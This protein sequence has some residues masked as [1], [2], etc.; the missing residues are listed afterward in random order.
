MLRKSLITIL[1]FILMTSGMLVIPGKAIPAAAQNLQSVSVPN[2]SLP[3]APDF[4]SLSFGDAWDM[5]EFTDISQYFNGAGRHPSLTNYS[6]ANG[7]FSARSIGDNLTGP[8]AAF[9]PLYEGYEN[10]MQIGGNLGSLHPI[11]SQKYNCLYLAMKVNSPTKT[12]DSQV[13]DIFRVYY[14]NASTSGVLFDYLYFEN[15]VWPYNPQTLGWRLYKVNLSSPAHLYPNSTRWQ[16]QPYWTR[17][18]INPTI[19]K[20]IDFQVDWIR[21]TNCNEE[22]EYQA[23]VSWSPDASINTIWARPSGTNR[24]IVVAR[25]IDGSDGAYQ[26]NTMGLAPGSYQI[27]LGTLSNCCTQWSN[28]ELTINQTPMA[29]VV[30]PSPTS[31]EDF[32][33]NA[34]N[35]WDM[36]PSDI[37]QISCTS[38]SYSDGQLHLQ[39]AY[40]AALPSSCRGP[41]LGEAD[42]RIY[43]N[44]P[45][46]LK[47]AKEYR[48]LSFELNMEGSYAMPADGMIGRFMW[49]TPNGCTQ[50]SADI[51][52]EVGQNTYV[53]D[54]Y[55]PFNGMPVAAAPAGCAKVP[56]SQTGEVL[57][58]RFDPNENYTGVYVPQMVFS[59]HFD[60]ISLSKAERV[61]QGQSYMVGLRL[62]KS[63]DQINNIEYYFTND[64]QNPIQNTA[65]RYNREVVAPL[66]ANHFIYLPGIITYGLPFEKPSV[67]TNF[68]WDTSGVAPGDYYICAKVYDDQNDSTFCSEA[69]VQVYNP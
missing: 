65:L 69:P 61:V 29:E 42:S 31:G 51:P 13:A 66:N 59:Q 21:L 45:G 1:I 58:L 26:L 22:P 14:S 39:T 12:N 6:V 34:G 17:L 62:N 49:A 30:Y 33:T 56:W 4:V 46:P 24:D 8:L 35:A 15:A 37:D 3:E 68:S 60:W 53:I 16:D 48:Y 44:M 67:D 64:P 23:Q 7:L 43:L 32:A 20:D 38:A 11:D 2:V 28:G 55:D 50:V 52:Y 9:Y 41:V 27:G 40:P 18:E 36:D 47:N 57:T 10:F 54:L 63:M 19:Y 5:S 25:D